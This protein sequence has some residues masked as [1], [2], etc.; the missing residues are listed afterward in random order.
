MPV[1]DPDNFQAVLAPGH[2]YVDGF[3]FKTVAPTKLDLEKTTTTQHI[4]DPFTF[5]Q[6][7]SHGNFIPMVR[8]SGELELTDFAFGK[9]VLL[10]AQT[11]DRLDDITS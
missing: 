6:T 5:S 4:S 9:H 8:L 1:F 10:Y 3:R 11:G 2:A 7:I